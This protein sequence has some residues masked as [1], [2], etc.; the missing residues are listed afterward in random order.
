AFMVFQ[1]YS[2]A[3]LY[4]TTDGIHPLNSVKYAAKSSAEVGEQRSMNYG[5]RTAVDLEAATSSGSAE[6]DEEESMLHLNLWVLVG[7]LVV[8]TVLVSVTAE[9][10]VDAVDGIVDEGHLSTEFV[11]IILLSVVGN[12]GDLFTAVS[13]AMKDKVNLSIAIAVGSS[14][15]TALFLTPFLVILGW[16]LGKPLTLLFDPYDSITLFVSVL[17]VNYVVQDGKSN[18]LEGFILLALYALVAV[19]FF[20]YPGQNT[21]VL[22]H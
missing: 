12:I 10:L 6:K 4:T 5:G 15:Q 9:W 14:I 13:M 19:T 17:I 22:C 21:S 3:A 2:H 8:V 16:I 7:S 1:L 11:G 18:W 20:F